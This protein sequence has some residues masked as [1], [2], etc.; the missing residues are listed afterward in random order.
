MAPLP[1]RKH[2]TRRKGKRRAEISHTLDTHIVKNESGINRLSH[3]IDSEGKYKGIQIIK[4]KKV[5]KSKE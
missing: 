4:P 3:R 1:K 2:S 5:K